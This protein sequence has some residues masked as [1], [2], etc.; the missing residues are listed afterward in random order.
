MS[1]RDVLNPIKFQFHTNPLFRITIFSSPILDRGIEYY[2]R[3]KV[4]AYCQTV[5]IDTSE[6]V[7]AI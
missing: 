4:G 5:A 7:D 3:Y 1:I 2:P 6:R